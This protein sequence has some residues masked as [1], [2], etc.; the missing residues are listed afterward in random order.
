MPHSNKTLADEITVVA[1]L[2]SAVARHA[3]TY[4][5]D[6]NPIC[7][8]LDVDPATFQSLTARISLDRFCRLLEACAVLANDEAFGLKCSTI[9][10]AGSTGPF[11]YGLI[12]A[13]TVRDMVTFL[14]SHTQ[15]A[16]HTSYLKLDANDKDWRLAWT[17]APIIS[18]RDQYVDMSVA[19]LMQRFRDIVGDLTDLIEVELERVKPRQPHIFRELISK[20][21]SFGTRDN[22]ICIPAQLLDMQ[23]PRGDEKLFNLMDIQCRMMRPAEAI[24]SEDFAD[25]V[26]SYMA[27]RTAEANVSLSDIAPYFGVSERTFQRR[28]A[29]HNT[30]L[31]EIRDEVR[32]D[33]SLELLTRSD[34]SISEICYRLG[35]SAPSAFTRSVN[36]WFGTS[37]K[38]MR[39]RGDPPGKQ[40]AV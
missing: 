35:Y 7:K 18:K 5:I 37:P 3:E 6:I 17:F 40:A 39:H 11:G 24:R 29:E 4:G 30:S 14:E 2:A 38:A 20:R 12:S 16:T 8:A 25:Q 34:L 32:R 19:L 23:N 13:P 36:R 27:L 1:G 15:Y 22:S 33:L 26:R 31:H 9:F 28:L 10:V 21:L